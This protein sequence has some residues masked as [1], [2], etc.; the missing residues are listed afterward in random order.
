MVE[1]H[2]GDNGE[3][4]SQRTSAELLTQGTNGSAP[5]IGDNRELLKQGTSGRAPQ[6]GDQW[7]SFSH[8][9]TMIGLHTQ[10]DNAELLT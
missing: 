9:G 6:A 5:K 8:R 2:T 10:G 1:L 7:E 4:L 3:L